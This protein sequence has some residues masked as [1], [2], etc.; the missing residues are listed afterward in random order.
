MI[1][2]HAGTLN[3]LVQ[4]KYSRP[5]RIS[6]LVPVSFIPERI[7]QSEM[8]SQ[9]VCVAQGCYYVH[10]QIQVS[11][12]FLSNALVEADTL[13]GVLESGVSESSKVKPVILISFKD[14]MVDNHRIVDTV[15]QFKITD[16]VFSSD[17]LTDT[18]IVQS[19]AEISVEWKDSTALETSYRS[20][21]IK[22]LLTLRPAADEKWLPSGPYFLFGK[23][24]HQAWRLYPDNLD[25]FATTVVQRD[26][27]STESKYVR[28]WY[29]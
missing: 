13:K 3:Y 19:S 18:V 12:S 11:I 14:G 4:S 10:P 23:N 27:Q 7:L 22:S 15:E 25:C 5:N 29:Y 20:W 21:L 16:D 26:T 24:L 6:L 1:H 2:D 8:Q 17:F 28:P 9:V